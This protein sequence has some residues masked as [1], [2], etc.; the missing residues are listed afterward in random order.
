MY[1]KNCGLDIEDKDIKNCPNCGAKIRKGLPV[2][3]V[4]LII[5]G[6][7]GCLGTM[8]LFFLGIVAAMT[9]PVLLSN[10]EKARTRTAYLKTL[11]ALNQ[12]LVLSEAMNDKLY[13]DSDEIWEKALKSRL[14]IDKDNGNSITLIDEVG[15]KYEKLNSTCT[16][17][18]DE[19]EVSE[20]TACAILT[21]DTDGFE[22]GQNE[23]SS[24]DGL[25]DRFS[26]LLYPNTLIPAPGTV[27]DDIVKGLDRKD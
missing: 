20:K 14:A 5:L 9:M 4:I 26:V 7:L 6:S 24:K 18:P 22:K 21:I 13:T 10:T 19:D 25:K 8:V 1:C 15:I 2:W 16:A 17:Y 23:Y 3:A 12:A 11:S 27:E